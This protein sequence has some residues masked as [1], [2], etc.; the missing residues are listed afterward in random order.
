MKKTSIL[1]LASLLLSGCWFNNSGAWKSSGTQ[2]PMTPP[3]TG[4][5]STAE[6]TA[7]PTQSVEEM[8]NETDTVLSAEM[9]ADF[10]SIDTDLKQLDEE[11][12]NY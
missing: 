2:K 12:K 10:K 6:P 4:G 11:L 9:D 8:G 7:I 3:P 5:P 1:I